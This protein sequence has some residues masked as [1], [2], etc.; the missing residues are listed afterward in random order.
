MRRNLEFQMHDNEFIYSIYSIWY[1][2]Y[3][4]YYTDVH[5][6]TVRRLVCICLC[7][8]CMLLIMTAR[9]SPV[10]GCQSPLA[11]L[12]TFRT[13]R[14]AIAGS[15]SASGSSLSLSCY[16]IR[17]PQSTIRIRINRHSKIYFNYS[18]FIVPTGRAIIYA[19]RQH[20]LAQ[21]YLL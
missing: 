12:A 4:T 7:N 18:H 6:C 11:S 2:V 19:N 17:N 14:I 10:A 9:R 20:V 16:F 8:L 21:E 1:M 3:G 13:R 5:I 15:G